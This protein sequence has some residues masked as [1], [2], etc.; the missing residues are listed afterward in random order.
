MS[1]SGPTPIM[2]SGL[3]RSGTTWMQWFLSSHPRIHVHGQSPKL[4]WHRLWGWYRTLVDQGRWAAEANRRV[5]Y[6]CA[7][8]AGSDAARCGELFREMFRRYMTGYGP[9]RPRWGLKWIDL[10]SNPKAVRQWESLWPDTR[11][12]ICVRDPFLTI[13]SAKNTFVPDLNLRAYAGR[14]VRT[15]RFIHEHD[16]G[17]VVSVQLDRLRGQTFEARR[18]AVGRVLALIGE[19]PSAGTDDFLR[20]WPVVH[21]VTPDEKREFT[22]AQ[23]T[24][25]MLLDEVPELGL[26]MQRLGYAVP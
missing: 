13:A 26:W 14:W 24:R 9:T 1:E 19:R 16:S 11:W 7:H 21:K 6:R 2:V 3:G 22:L 8:Y 25:Q 15:C 10:A 4:P 18:A 23:E 5:G 12:V 17:R 20:R